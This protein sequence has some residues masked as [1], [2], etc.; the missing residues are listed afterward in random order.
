MTPGKVTFPCR[1]VDL[2]L[3]GGMSTSNR[4]ARRELAD[5]RGLDSLG[6]KVVSGFPR[7]SESF[8]QGR[9]ILKHPPEWGPLLQ[10][11]KAGRDGGVLWP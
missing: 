10:V 9:A 11:T 7:N 8:P 3:K 6:S 1:S 2:F 5:F 4:G